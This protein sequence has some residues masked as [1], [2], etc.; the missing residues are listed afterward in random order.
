MLFNKR[1]YQRTRFKVQ[2]LHL[3]GE[4]IILEFNT[5]FMANQRSN[6]I[7]YKQSLIF[8][9]YCSIT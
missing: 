3:K 1:S 7:E 4:D 2:Q 9:T 6:K 5:K 8:T